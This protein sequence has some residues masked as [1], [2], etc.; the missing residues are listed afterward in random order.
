MLGLR[1]EVPGSDAT[2][3]FEKPRRLESALL[4]RVASVVCGAQSDQEAPFDQSVDELH[5]A[6]MLKLHSFRQ[7]AWCRFSH[8]ADL[9]PLKQLMLC[10]SI[11]VARGVFT[12]TEKAADLVAQFR[13]RF[14]LVGR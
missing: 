3:V 13:H 6:V 8:R 2:R 12:E 1:I 14:V 7:H 5:G 4:R 10:G 9:G 11:P